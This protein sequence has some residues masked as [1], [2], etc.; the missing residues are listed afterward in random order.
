MNK[1]K[2]LNILSNN[3]LIWEDL[4]LDEVYQAYIDCRKNKSTKDS[5]IEFEI[6]LFRNLFQI[7]REL[8]TRIYKISESIRFVVLEPSPREVWAA[9]FRDRIV[10]HIVYNRIKETVYRKL[11]PDTCA[12][13]PGKG[14]H[15]AANKAHRY[16]QSVTNNWKE[17]AWYL[18]CDFK[19]FFGSL[20]K[21]II[22]NYVKEFFKDANKDTMWL[23]EKIIFHDPRSNYKNNSTPYKDSLIPKHKSLLYNA[24]NVGL[25]IGNILSQI[26]ANL[27]LNKLDHFI[28]RTLKI[29]Y[30]RY[31][32]DFVLIDK[33]KEKL[34]RALKLIKPIISKLELTLND[35]KTFIQKT[36]R[37]VDFIGFVS[38]PYHLE[39]RKRTLKKAKTAI[40]SEDFRKFQTYLGIMKNGNNQNKTRKYCNLVYK[41]LN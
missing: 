1:R 35:K 17:D 34:K 38:K 23:L 11:S 2:I 8:R 36:S 32:D 28:N 25:A 27:I 16:V 7:Y 39:I 12:C 13:I 4:T 37:G 19:N 26:L 31:V 21:N 30:V 5:T 10:Q 24:P 14:T 22:F 9:N 15:Y 41:Y 18:K 6:E 40:Y 3:E 20:N 29:K 33:D